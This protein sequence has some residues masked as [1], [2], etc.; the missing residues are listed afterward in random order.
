MKLQLYSPGKNPSPLTYPLFA[1][2]VSCGFPSP[3]ADYIEFDLELHYYCI[4]HPS[5]TYYL[6]P[7]G[8]VCLTAAFTT[9]I[10]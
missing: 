6:R 5:A 2:L 10:C 3:A 4:R 1:E 8:T 7:A 9:A